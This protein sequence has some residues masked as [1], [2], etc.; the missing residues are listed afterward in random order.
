MRPFTTRLHST[1]EEEAVV[2]KAKDKLQIKLAR[3]AS[4]KQLDQGS[5]EMNKELIRCLHTK[6]FEGAMKLYTEQRERFRTRHQFISLL[7]VCQRAEHLD[8]ALGLFKTMDEQFGS[9][10]PAEQAFLSLIRC[11][12]ADDTEQDQVRQTVMYIDVY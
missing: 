8:T 1:E 6:D 12:T 9:S 3:K 2:N 5:K 4:M 11:Y 10:E 7:N